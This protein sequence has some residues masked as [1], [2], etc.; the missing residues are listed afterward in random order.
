[1]SKL[2]EQDAYIQEFKSKIKEVDK[3]QNII[4]L[5]STAFYAKSGGQPGDVGKIIIN[6]ITVE[7]LDT[8]KRDNKIINIVNSTNDLLQDAEI[9]GKINW[10]KRYKYMKMHSALHLMCSVIPLGVTGGQIG[11]EKSRLD[12]NDPDK[13]INKEELEEKLNS[14]V[15]DDHQI[16]SEIIESKIL[17]EQPELVRTMSVKPP[18]ID[19]KIRLIKIGNIDLQPCGGTHVKSTSEIGEIKIGKI[20]NKGRMNRRIN[21]LI[22]D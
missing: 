1:M 21:I 9:E 20:E 18:Q 14:L 7:V 16:T 8:V 15:K 17:D 5:E 22:N 6:E 2:F 19:G 10:E 11:F 13:K 12:F 4:E 3:S